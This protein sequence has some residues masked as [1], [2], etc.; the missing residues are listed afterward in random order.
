MGVVELVDRHLRLYF[1]QL[2]A[3]LSRGK[4]SGWPSAAS[5][6][7][8]ALLVMEQAGLAV[9]T[10]FNTAS[11]TSWII[12]GCYVLFV[13]AFL[14]CGVRRHTPGPLF[15][16]RLLFEKAISRTSLSLEA[17]NNALS[18]AS[19]PRCPRATSKIV[20]GVGMLV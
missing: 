6:R 12:C 4:L 18:S 17:G 10:Y 1:W 14:D 2:R 5:L 20:S 9:E 19:L 8:A 7:R 3:K 13:L 11:T 16:L 15:T